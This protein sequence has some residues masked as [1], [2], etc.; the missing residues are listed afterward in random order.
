MR[1]LR[2]KSNNKNIQNWIDGKKQ[3]DNSNIFEEKYI[4]LGSKVG[5]EVLKQDFIDNSLVKREHETGELYLHNTDEWYIPHCAAL[6]IL[7][8]L[9]HG[10]DNSVKPPKHLSSALP[11]LL[12]NLYKHSL[13]HSGA[14]AYAHF[15]I[16]L[17][18]YIFFDRL[19][20]EDIKQILQ[21][22]LHYLDAAVFRRG[23]SLFVNI[24]LDIN[25][26]NYLEYF[27][28]NYICNDYKCFHLGD[29]QDEVDLF[30]KA[31]LDLLIQGKN[32]NFPFTFP[33]ITINYTNDIKNKKCDSE[34]LN[35]IYI[36]TSK[37][38]S[39]YFR[40]LTGKLEK[41]E[42]D[43]I[44]MCCHLRIDQKK[45]HRGGLW[46][47]DG[48]LMQYIGG[49][50]IIT[51]NLNRIGILAKDDN[52]YF[53]IL[54]NLIEKAAKQLIY[55]HQICSWLLNNNRYDINYKSFENF[56]LILGLAGGHESMVNFLNKG[57]WDKTAQNFAIKILDFINAKLEELNQKTDYLFSLE[58]PPLEKASHRLANKDLLYFKD[59]YTTNKANNPFLTP[60]F[61]YPIDSLFLDINWREKIDTKFHSGTIYHIWD[62]IYRDSYEMQKFIE[63]FSRYNIPYFTYTPVLSICNKCGIFYGL[64]YKC[65]KCEKET[66]ITSKIVGYMRPLQNWNL[67][68]RD[69]LKMRRYLYPKLKE[70]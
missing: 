65:P 51:L 60:G 35:K 34:V 1:C 68:K 3:Y 17:A 29:F 61:N 5:T 37:Y 44:S 58:C 45:Y 62:G 10:Y 56:F 9:E 32:D 11:Q 18:P 41:H 2:P 25:I 30:N 54:N 63:K 52:Q 66:Q 8:I 47:I 13:Y 24:T 49:L 67:A 27:K 59:A 36:L 48:G 7:D 70:V 39:I 69:E 23:Q 43:I 6:S 55:N 31:L 14:L 21:N 40:N 33:L 50:N 19:S 28:I 4:V 22:F 42:K 64:E 12:S 53:E 20:Y 57:I 15:D 16:L 38:G 46:N 26:P